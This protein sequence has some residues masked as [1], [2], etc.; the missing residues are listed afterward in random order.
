MMAQRYRLRPLQ[1]G[2]P[3][4]DVGGML[5]GAVDQGRLQALDLGIQAVEGVAHPKPEIG[6]HL[7]VPGSGRGQPP[8]GVADQIA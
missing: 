3:R 1:V 7:V 5:L 4:H 8:G 2:Q 6:G